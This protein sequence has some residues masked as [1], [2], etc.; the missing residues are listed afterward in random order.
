M[1]RATQFQN[2]TDAELEAD[3]EEEFADDG[4]EILAEEVC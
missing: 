4:D 1:R 2:A 3:Q